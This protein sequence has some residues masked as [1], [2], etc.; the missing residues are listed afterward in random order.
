[1]TSDTIKP[2]SLRARLAHVPQELRF[3]TSGRRGPVVHLTQ[4]EIYLNVLAELEYLQ[5][6]P[7]AAGG[8]RR[9]EEFFYAYDLRP[10]SSCYVEAQQGRGELAQAAEAA[11]RAA[12]M[13]PV[14]LGRIPTPALAHY[15]WAR[16]KGSLMVTGSHIPFDRNGYKLNTARGELLKHH[17][18]PIDAQVRLVRARLYDQP[19]AASPFDEQGRF[20]SGH[21][22]LVEENPAAAVA[23]QRRYRDF[24]GS[25]ALAGMRLLVYQHSAVGR[26]LLPQIL[27][28]LGAR[29]ETTGR[30]DT[31]VPID[32]ENIDAE[33]LA[34]IQS[35]YQD[36]AARYGRFDAVVSTD[37]DSDR[38]L[39]LG[40]DPAS[41][42]LRFFS[43]D[44]VGMVAA[45]YLGADA[46]VVP[47]S[48]NDAID[49]GP[50]KPLLE[51]KT[52]IGSPY[53]I[54]AM[55]AARAR[56]KRAVCGFEAN[57]GFLTG[58]DIA[59]DG[60]VLAA[61]P[62]RDAVLPLV[63]VLC[64]ARERGLALTELFSRLP[65]RFGRAALLRP[66]PRPL[67]VR[68]VEHWQPADPDLQE[69][70]FQPQGVVALDG[71]GRPRPL[72]E[73]LRRSL[74][75]IRE[76]LG[77]FFSPS[78]GFGAITALNYVDGLRIRFDNG[79]VAHL[80]PSGNADELRI[81]AVADNQAR[82]DAI[83]ALGVA[84]PDGILRRLAERVG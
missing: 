6:L 82:A 37:G 73:A 50:L 39:L 17:E 21:R 65:Q 27:G 77:E 18:A 52:R 61:L 41:S 10:S 48:C 60:R 51:P 46:V 66:F 64:A 57:G 47:I 76:E 35:L 83:A 23:Y 71:A 31:F 38:P 70:Q 78:L 12:G 8:I 19:F 2:D 1:M 36:A 3:G 81:Y 53:V 80:R 84:E 44:L 16:G 67:G 28:E 40:V 75:A 45:E 55:E 58:S 20:K 13:T 59:R 42:A 68:L 32:T 26:D 43:G 33:Q 74:T 5:S 7:M 54:A 34:I 4:L 22:A 79:D 72:T 15:A 25:G 14:N 11:I 9:G 69:A 56:G 49:R 29:V 63:A 30:S 62:T 24:F